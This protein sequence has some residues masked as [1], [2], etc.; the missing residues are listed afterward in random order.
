M[1]IEYQEPNRMVH[2]IMVRVPVEVIVNE[3]DVWQEIT[4]ALWRLARR[5]RFTVVVSTEE[6]F[7]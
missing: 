7:S 5:Y 2:C 4:S 3:P 1:Y 6:G